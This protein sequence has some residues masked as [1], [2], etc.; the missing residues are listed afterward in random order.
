MVRFIL[1]L[2]LLHVVFGGCGTN[3]VLDPNL[4]GCVC[5]AGYVMKLTTEDCILEKALQPGSPLL[6]PGAVNI[7]SFMLTIWTKTPA[8]SISSGNVVIV[9]KTKQLK[10]A[11][12][13][14]AKY[15][16]TSYYTDGTSTQVEST[17]V[18][19]PADQW[20]LIFIM[21]KVGGNRVKGYINNNELFNEDITGKTLVYKDPTIRFSVCTNCGL[22]KYFR[23]WTLTSCDSN[24]MNFLK[25]YNEEPGMDNFLKTQLR[26]DF[27]ESEGNFIWEYGNNMRQVPLSSGYAWVAD[28]S[29]LCDPRTEYYDGSGNPRPCTTRSANP[30]WLKSMADTPL[31]FDIPQDTL[32]SNILSLLQ[33]WVKPV[34]SAVPSP[35][36][37]W[38]LGTYGALHYDQDTNEYVIDVDNSPTTVAGT[39]SQWSVIQFF[40]G[41]QQYSMKVNGGMPVGSTCN[42]KTYDN[43]KQVYIG[44]CS[45]I[46][47]CH[48]SRAF[49][50]YVRNLMIIK[51]APAENAADFQY[52][53]G[54]DI[55]NAVLHV[56]FFYETN[57]M[58]RDYANTLNYYPMGATDKYEFKADTIP[59]V[60]HN[61]MKWDTSTSHCIDTDN[62]V[63][64]IVGNPNTKCIKCKTHTM[65][66]GETCPCN[67]D[68]NLQ[69][70]GLMCYDCAVYC[71]TCNAGV[72][73]AC[74]YNLI[75]SDNRCICPPATYLL[76][77][78]S[79]SCVPAC[80]DGLRHS[81]EGC[82]DGNTNSGDGCSNTC[83]VEQGYICTGGTPTSPDAC[84][85]EPKISSAAYFDNWTKVV[86]TFNLPL[87]SSNVCPAI[88]SAD[89]NTKLGDS[90]C[91]ISSNS[92]TLVI[93]LG[94]NLN[95]DPFTYQFVFTD[96]ALLNFYVPSC[97]LAGISKK[98]DPINGPYTIYPSFTATAKIVDSVNVNV[99]IPNLNAGVSTFTKT[100]VTYAMSDVSLN[101][102]LTTK[103]DILDFTIPEAQLV[104]NTTY[105]LT[106]NAKNFLNLDHS[107]VVQIQYLF[108]YVAPSSPQENPAPTPSPNPT[109]IPM[110]I[111]TPTPVPENN[112]PPENITK[113]DN[114]TIPENVTNPINQTYSQ[115]PLNSLFVSLIVGGLGILIGATWGKTLEAREKTGLTVFEQKSFSIQSLFGSNHNDKIGPQISDKQISQLEEILNIKLG[116]DKGNAENSRLNQSSVLEKTL[117]VSQFALVNNNNSI[118]QGDTSRNDNT[119]RG[120]I[121][122][123]KTFSMTTMRSPNH[124][125]QRNVDGV[126]T[127]NG[128]LRPNSDIV[129]AREDQGE[130]NPEEFSGRVQNSQEPDNSN[131]RLTSGDYFSILFLLFK[132]F[133]NDI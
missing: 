101:P 95:F 118:V 52:I 122:G 124:K 33:I 102:F 93:T 4:K 41:S 39:I 106:V 96:Q 62:G 34:P 49:N 78:S 1:Y 54:F 43:V 42:A 27:R 45:G 88:F 85:C 56:P 26:Y 72:C 18:S 91:S 50:G 126:N 32:D 64:G 46:S 77:P 68:G 21:F 83:T 29:P 117:N 99:K 48:A 84:S 127:D 51:V 76:T 92:D 59:E 28:T 81:S 19:H 22:V 6:L 87:S 133:F 61:T 44:Y 58:I 130:E 74:Q 120:F 40:Y 116:K 38:A 121:T 86:V 16:W 5:A 70:D 13:A 71:T 12:T 15:Q 80:G 36:N 111:P 97:K 89:T 30:L 119:E 123:L 37:I 23:I 108:P 3:Q 31:V 67:I 132:V 65:K 82:D 2:F 73:S 9:E 57:K 131:S 125:S 104:K 107:E 114:I 75:V 17:T 11:V 109:P 47:F 8:A 90:L 7:N 25:W 35:E 20:T 79:T 115:I 69:S 94:N 105:S 103:Q 53:N 129:S 113:P 55:K 66:A 24:C 100:T 63:C 10:L 112:T 110:P 98:P 128:A 60:C 14:S